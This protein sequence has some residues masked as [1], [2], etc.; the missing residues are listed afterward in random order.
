MCLTNLITS[1]YDKIISVILIYAHINCNYIALEFN[2]IVF[3]LLNRT[4]KINQ[5]VDTIRGFNV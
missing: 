2:S 1:G 3:I 4:V 5:V